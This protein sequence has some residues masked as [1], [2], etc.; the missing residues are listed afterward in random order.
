MSDTPRLKRWIFSCTM[1]V[2]SLLFIELAL[3]AVY[4]LAKREF[5]PFRWYRTAIASIAAG[6]DSPVTPDL[7]GGEIQ[8]GE[9]VE[10]IHPYF[11]FV[12]DPSRTPNTSYLG[13]PQESDDPFAEGSS[14]ALVIAVCGGSFAQGVASQGRV[15]LQSTLQSQGIE[16]RVVNLAM[17]GYKQP[18]QLSVLTWLLSHDAPIDVVINID[19]F[20]EVALPQAE[21]LPKGVNPFYPRAWF[22]RTQGLHDREALRLTGQGVFLTSARQKWAKLF[23]GGFSWSISLNILWRAGDKNMERAIADINQALLAA[24]GSGAGF[25]TTGPQQDI[26]EEQ[27]YARI[28]SH[29]RSCSLQ[30]DTL[31]NSRRIIYI[32]FLQPNQYFEAGRKLTPDERTLAYRDDHPYRPGV[33][34]GYPYLIEEGVKLLSAGVDFH[35]LTFIYQDI[36]KAIYVDNCC[37]PNR[38]GYEIVAQYVA[39][40]IA[41]GHKKA[42]AE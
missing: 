19:G 34:S 20:N 7:R 18:Q 41:A 42:T 21:N 23:R 36:P 26:P 6:E 33:I 29:W 15:A 1:L 28:A 14:N 39:N 27:L 25:I 11:G 31:C 22:L 13:F 24:R 3:H 2:V 9:E 37:H 32:H 10:V 4:L 17:G 12:R 38:L 8:M 5:F 35:D 30:M 40:A 16:S